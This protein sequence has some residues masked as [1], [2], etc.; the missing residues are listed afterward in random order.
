[1]SSGGTGPDNN[2]KDEHH[3]E[4][5]QK[6][7][8]DI[9]ICDSL[10]ATSSNICVGENISTSSF[11]NL[12]VS[13]HDEIGDGKHVDEDDYNDYDAND[14]II[15]ASSGIVFGVS[16]FIKPWRSESYVSTSKLS[17][18]E[19]TARMS[20]IR[21]DNNPSSR[22]LD[23]SSPPHFIDGEVGGADA[24]ECNNTPRSI[25]GRQTKKKYNVRRADDESKST[26]CQRHCSAE[27]EHQ[28]AY[29]ETVAS[30][31]GADFSPMM[32]RT[33]E[34]S[35]G[36]FLRVDIPNESTNPPP[37]PLQTVGY[38]I[39]SRPM[40]NDPS[41]LN[42]A[43]VHAGCGMSDDG[44]RRMKTTFCDTGDDGERYT[45]QEG[46]TTK[47]N[48]DDYHSP[49]K[50][51]GSTI[52]IN[53]ITDGNGPL[54]RPIVD[55]ALP[56]AVQS[57]LSNAYGFNAFVFVGRM[58]NPERSSIATAA[59]SS[60]VGVQIVIF[61]LHNVLPSGANTHVSQCA[62]AGDRAMA[63]LYFRSAFYSSVVVGSIVGLVGRVSVVGI[64][65]MCNSDDPRVTE[66]IR[67][68][69]GII[70]LTS[71]FFS[72]MLLVDGFFKSIG[73]ASTPFKLELVSLVL[74]SVLNYIM[75]VHFDYGIGGSAIAASMARLVPA[76]CGLHRILRGENRGIA[77]SLSLLQD[78]PPG[79]GAV[80]MAAQWEGTVAAD[81][82]FMATYGTVDCTPYDRVTCMDEDDDDGTEGEDDERTLG[83]N[84]RHM[85]TTSSRMARIGV[86]DSIAACIYGACFTSLV[87]ICGLLGEKEQA[88]LG[89]G[90]RGVE[91]LA[92]CLSEGFLVAAATSVGQCVGAN[93]HERAMDV[94]IVCCSLSAFAAGSLGVPFVLWPEEISRA[95]V[96]D[97]EGIVRYCAQY[98]YV[99]GWVMSLIGFEMACYGSLLGAGRANIACF[100][101]GACNILRIPLAIFC[102]YSSRPAIEI[103]W[104]TLWA[105][106]LSG[107]ENF[108]K[109]TGDF[110]CIGGVIAFTACMKA[111]IWFGYFSYLWMSGRYLR[112][113]SLVGEVQ[114]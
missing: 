43:H 63:G 1:M 73:D 28:E 40:N 88:G 8:G 106:G 15:L 95:L 45:N 58:R 84:L 30:L 16:S 87:R 26:S 52:Q 67:E 100:V 14:N 37:P 24:N 110:Y 93:A 60:V 83:L 97:D 35:S 48:V 98:V 51:Q 57:I 81:G 94:A 91:W 99:Q 54:V 90:L 7:R 18:S 11:S 56:S 34:S 85:L 13:L 20:N 59:L 79:R 77:V 92:F 32:S 33:D 12:F 75:V 9:I 50:S 108:P 68:Y 61:A 112:G 103:A 111:I 101:N 5:Q 6:Q 78:L 2:N 23:C 114:Q 22:D 17:S 64:S 41:S 49:C 21:R 4:Q 3:Q 27:H 47:R 19:N 96:S 25:F 104:M 53:P 66:A 62:G 107:M 69:L 44:K 71:P 29:D 72:V 65:D 39:F 55:L 80:E 70:F 82:A 46:T 89:A 86:F 38:D 113:A 105:F 36:T 42:P 31:L 76:L 10:P 109:P 74:N 102:L